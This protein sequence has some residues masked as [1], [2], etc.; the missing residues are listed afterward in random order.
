MDALLHNGADVNVRDQRG[1]VATYLA[2][3]C[4]QVSILSN[5][6]AVS[7]HLY[8]YI[9]NNE[10][11]GHLSDVLFSFFLLLL[12]SMVRVTSAL[13]LFNSLKSVMQN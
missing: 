7:V 5:L 1:R 2:A 10:I 6:L 4:G 11:I 9:Y 12:S 8:M 13:S 3:T